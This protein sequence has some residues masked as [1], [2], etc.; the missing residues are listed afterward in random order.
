MGSDESFRPRGSDIQ[1]ILTNPTFFFFHRVF[2][3]CDRTLAE[4]NTGT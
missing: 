2:L 4:T 1:E 3:G